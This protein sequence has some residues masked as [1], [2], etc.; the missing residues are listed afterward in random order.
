MKSPVLL[1]IKVFGTYVL[2]SAAGLIL[3][4]NL[5]LAPLGLPPTQEIWVRVLGLVVGVLGYYYWASALVNARSFF[6]ASVYGRS[7]FCAGCIGLVLLA[8]APWQL[9]IFG[10]ID[11]AGAIWTR[12]ALRNE[13]P[14]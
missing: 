9:I 2:V 1:T 14:A 4:P 8:S 12:A 10:S 6:V 3:I 11:L 7:I 5:W 13:A